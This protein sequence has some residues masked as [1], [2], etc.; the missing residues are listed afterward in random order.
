LGHFGGVVSLQK[1]AVSAPLGRGF[2]P[3]PSHRG[4]TANPTQ[5]CKSRRPD[6][7]NDV[8]KASNTPLVLFSE[9]RRKQPSKTEKMSI[10]T[11]FSVPLRIPQVVI[12]CPK[13]EETA[14]SP[15]LRSKSVTDGRKCPK[16]GTQKPDHL[17]RTGS[18]DPVGGIDT[19]AEALA[20]YSRSPKNPALQLLQKSSKSASAGS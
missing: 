8:R 19:R 12:V 15:C 9:T 18:Y 20:H 5:G 14:L 4:A 10:I 11:P 2:A 16:N 3:R 6:D 13:R 7:H 1:G 17:I